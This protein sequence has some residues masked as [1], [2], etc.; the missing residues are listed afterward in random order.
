MQERVLNHER[1]YFS[2]IRLRQSFEEDVLG[3]IDTIGVPWPWDTLENTPNTCQSWAIDGSKDSDRRVRDDAKEQE[4]HS[5]K[6]NHD[7]ATPSLIQMDL[8]KTLMRADE[9]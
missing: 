7:R 9:S 2:R 3:R 6:T 4:K 1:T 8:E 5:V